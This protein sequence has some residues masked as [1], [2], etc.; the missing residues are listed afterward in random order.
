MADEHPRSQR[1]PRR[2]HG[3]QVAQLPQLV[4]KRLKVLEFI[5]KRL[6]DPESTKYYAVGVVSELMK[7]IQ[8]ARAKYL[9]VGHIQ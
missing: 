7:R 3:G 5:E 1:H 2:I 4:A 9:A 6:G 8:D